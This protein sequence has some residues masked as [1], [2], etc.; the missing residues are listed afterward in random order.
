MS[1][2]APYED[3]LLYSVF[4]RLLAYIQ[5]TPGKQI[6]NLALFGNRNAFAVGFG[7]RLNDIAEKTRPIWNAS[8]DGLISKMTLLPFYGY[9]LPPEQYSK[10][11]NRL[12]TGEEKS[13][14]VSLGFINRLFQTGRTPG[15]AA[16]VR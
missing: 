4:A 3:E 5:P 13:L 16:L 1:I 12:K 15:S 10:C 14:L 11:L 9:Y 2:P 8:S 6:V 7:H